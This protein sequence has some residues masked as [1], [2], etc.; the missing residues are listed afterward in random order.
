MSSCI[1]VSKKLCI[2]M[3]YF[4]G[5]K[6]ICIRDLGAGLYARSS[7]R[8]HFCLLQRSPARKTLFSKCYNATSKLKALCSYLDEA[9]ATV[10]LARH[11]KL[12]VTGKEKE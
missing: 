10:T 2:S 6:A 1:I 7:D 12:W 5:P 3:S 9:R 4:K 8:I 11:Q